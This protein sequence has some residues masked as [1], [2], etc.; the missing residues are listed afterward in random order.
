MFRW[1]SSWEQSSFI[2]L[3][4]SLRHPIA[5]TAVPTSQVL[6]IAPQLAHIRKIWRMG[7]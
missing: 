2:E 4:R 1:N 5:A 7:I 3:L 6:S